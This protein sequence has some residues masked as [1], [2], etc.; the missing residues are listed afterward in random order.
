M[1]RLDVNVYEIYDEIL[2][3]KEQTKQDSS[4][5]CTVAGLVYDNTL[6]V[7]L[8]DLADHSTTY[9]KLEHKFSE[10]T[11]SK[12]KAI[13]C[14]GVSMYS[15]LKL[16]HYDNVHNEKSTAKRGEQDIAQYDTIPVKI[17]SAQINSLDTSL[18]PQNTNL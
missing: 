2:P 8:A 1:Y 9:S 17:A 15:E 3:E 12:L 5:K 18:L 6:H 11:T 14:D 7:R 10:K 4:H 16:D 13:N